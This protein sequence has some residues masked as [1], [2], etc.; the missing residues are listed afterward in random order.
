MKKEA[1]KFLKNE[2]KKRKITYTKLSSLM[3]KRGYIYS[4]NTI[5]SKINRGSF[6]FAFLL[7]VCDSLDIDL[8][9]I[10]SKTY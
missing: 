3:E 9:C 6:S 2:L 8:V 7:E 1:S 5:R 10:D 4:A